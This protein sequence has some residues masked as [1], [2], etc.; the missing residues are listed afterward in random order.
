MSINFKDYVAN[1]QDFPEPG[2]IFRD[3]SPLME[4][5]RAYAAATNAIVD[6]ARAKNVEMVCGPE[7]RGFIV[8]CP[9]AYKLGVG[10]APA[11]KK[12]K[13]P[14][15]TVSVTYDLEYGQASLYM[16]KD[17]VKPGQ[18]V[19]VVDDLMATGGTLAATIKLVEELGGIVVG[20]AFLIELTDLHGRDKIK[21]YD[22]F[23]LMQY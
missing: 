4:D 6:Y 5:G 10:F 9:V 7:A 14:Q 22:M 11:R 1:V 13:L 15:P 23:T 19:L 12:G 18:R 3:I 20:T 17:A 16:H 2:I 8:G 21:G